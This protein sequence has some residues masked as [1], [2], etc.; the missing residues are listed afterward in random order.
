MKAAL[1]DLPMFRMYLME[2][3]TLAEGSIRMYTEGIKQ[4]LAGNP[5]I[6]KLEDY[7]NFVIRTAVKKRATYVYSA[8]KH[9][10]KF[11]SLEPSVKEN[12][13]ENM[14][15]PE[16][17]D[18]IITRV[19]LPDEKRID[20]I[21]HLEREK[22]QVVALIQN[23]TGV[24]AGDILRLRKGR[25]FYEEQDG[26]PVIRLDLIGKRKKK[27]NTHIFDKTVQ[28][29][30]VYYITQVN[31][32]LMEEYY[33]LESSK[34]KGREGQFENEEL[35]VKMNYQ[36]YWADL[37]Q[38]LQKAGV[39]NTQFATHDFRRCFS[40]EIWEKYKDL[41]ILQRALQHTNPMTTI[42]Y[43]NQSGMQNKDILKDMQNKAYNYKQ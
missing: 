39:D 26:Q 42:R 18:P 38:A 41:Q 2:K 36:W 34:A 24:R 8:L 14:I 13:I 40:R 11:M 21:N 20:V 28:D 1:M 23:L 6:D 16:I 5:D 9:F 7:N 33:F 17:K 3:T 22:H 35:M 29:I 19:Y 32:Q 12:L 25:L 4:F 30:L 27:I 31:E 15:K 37:K 10:I 43:L